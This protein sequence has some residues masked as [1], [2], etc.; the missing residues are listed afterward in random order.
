MKYYF[1]TLNVIRITR[2][3]NGDFL[4]ENE[5]KYRKLLDHHPFLFE[6]ETNK[7][8]NL[9]IE[10]N[11][12]LSNEEYKVISYQEITEHEYHIYKDFIE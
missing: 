5:M 1:A 4:S 3:L 11:G 8:Y 2:K 6:L 7:K 12:Y 10:K 9:N